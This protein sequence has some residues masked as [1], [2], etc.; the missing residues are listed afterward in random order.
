MDAARPPARTP[1]SPLW[2]RPW[3]VGTLAAVVVVAGALAALVA[4]RGPFFF[5]SCDPQALL[6]RELGKSTLVLGAKGAVIATIAPEHEN[7]PVALDRI[8]PWLQRATVAIEDRRFFEHEGIDYRGTLR[9]LVANTGEGTVVQG[10][11]TITQQLARNLYLGSEQSVSRKLTEG[12]LAVELEREWS[13]ERI[14]AG[15]LN[16]VYYGNRAYGAE[17]AARTYFSK[18][19]AKLTAAE[20]AL[21]AGLPQSPSRLD[22]LAAPERARARRSEVLTAMV[23]TGALSARQA[24]EIRRQPLRLAPS[25]AYGQ[26]RDPY[27]ASFVAEQ[28]TERYGAEVLREG[29]LRVYTTIDARM[30]RL[31]RR[32]VLRTLDR[33]GDPAAAVVAIDPKNGAVRALASIVPGR[34]TAFNLAVDGKRQPG[35]TFKTFVLAEAIRRGID[36]WRTKY[37]SAPFDGP[38]F[39]GKPW[40]VTTYDGTYLGRPS[41]AAAT[42][43]S[44][45]SV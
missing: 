45:N 6:E 34:R 16:R 21:L 13:K 5:V 15:Y 12:C 30:Q 35:S 24:D 26:Q 7:R 40:Q 32:A 14:L 29:G 8:S 25:P 10:G 3:L 31:A 2:R 23:E 36:P 39:G 42:L 44:D 28:L 4:A 18:P 11:S 33:R 9:A 38:A 27:L 17:A 19:A 1:R 43:A 22:P 20:A 41:V 37:L